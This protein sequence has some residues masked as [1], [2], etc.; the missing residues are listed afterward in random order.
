MRSDENLEKRNKI[1]GEMWRNETTGGKE[2]SQRRDR[3]LN[4]QR[5]N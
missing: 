1:R 3:K 5:L 4:E 2:R